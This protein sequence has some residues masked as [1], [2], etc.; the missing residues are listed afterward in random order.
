M[1]DFGADVDLESFRKEARDWLEENFPKSLAHQPGI[2]AAL[3]DGPAPSG[4]IGLWKQR[5]GEKGWGTPTWPKE[6]GGGG[7]SGQ[8]ARVLQQEM[9]RIGAFNPLTAGMGVTMIGPTILDYGTEEQ[10]R[11]HIPPIVRG[12][13]RWAVGYSEPG[14]GS[15][16][17]S[18]QT[19]CED[20]GDHWLING[21]KIWT[22]GAQYSDWI[23][24][25]VRTDFTVKKHDGITFLLVDMHQ[26]GIEVRPI[27]LIAGASPFCETFFTD[28]TAPKEAMLGKL[29]EGWSVGKR[30]LQH[31]RASQTGA[32]GGGGGG[33]NAAPFQEV[34]KRYVGMDADGR[35]A[36][37]DL[38][39]RLTRHLMDAKAHGLTLARAAAESKGASGATNAASVLKN[40]ATWVSQT[41][42][43]LTLEIFGHQGLGWE[44]EAFEKEELEAVRGWLSGKA[45]SIYGGSQEIQ[46][47]IISKR[48]LGL[49]D[50]TQST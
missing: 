32:M 22:S 20:M 39:T 28:A 42:A 37:V 4:D 10:K 41:R 35:I 11:K 33:R 34:A 23:G 19:K 50:T 25:L 26:P 44:G 15:D 21:Q 13:V 27:K 17:A 2:A 1:A 6:Y 45:M 47:N 49:P 40:S 16:L 5:M 9:A 24:M 3:M 14:A 48:I 46:N 36:D 7:L 8:E 18:L 31:E 38:R 29:N 30:L 12:E 43:E